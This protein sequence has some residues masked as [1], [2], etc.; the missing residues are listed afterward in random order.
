MS[1]KRRLTV[2]ERI[3]RNMERQVDMFDG[4]NIQGGDLT[5]DGWR[6]HHKGK[7]S[8]SAS[9]SMHGKSTRDVYDSAGNA[10]TPERRCLI[11]YTPIG[12]SYPIDKARELAHAPASER[13]MAS[14]LQVATAANKAGS[15]E[16]EAEAMRRFERARDKQE[17]ERDR[18]AEELIDGISHRKRKDALTCSPA[19]RTILYKIR[20]LPKIRQKAEWLRLAKIA[21]RRGLLPEGD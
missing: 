5:L 13:N 3:A 19:C 8:N 10:G 11:C 12:R 21:D 18:N 1:R 4:V 6:R 17:E 20:K 9:Q 7:V 2:R 14:A 15:K 16:C